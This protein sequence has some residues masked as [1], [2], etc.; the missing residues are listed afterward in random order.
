MGSSNVR[1]Y[2]TAPNDDYGRNY[3]GLNNG[4]RKTSD[5]IVIRNMPSSWTWQTLR[6]KF[7][8]VGEVKFAEIKGQDTGVVRFA[9]ERDADVAIKLID[10]SR[11]EGRTIDAKFF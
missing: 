7:R 1:N 3:G 2:S 11:F 8:D 9:K 4:N 6:D 5:T 10:G